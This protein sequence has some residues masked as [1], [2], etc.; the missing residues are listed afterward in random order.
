MDTF[1]VHMGGIDKIIRLLRND[2]G[3]NCEDSGSGFSQPV[4]TNILKNLWGGVGV[5]VFGKILHRDALDS[6]ILGNIRGNGYQWGISIAGVQP[7]KILK[8]RKR[9]GIGSVDHWGTLPMPS[10]IR[11]PRAFAIKGRVPLLRQSPDQH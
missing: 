6:E 5:P 11:V 8:S 3:R 4:H 9:E 7:D 2:R 1:E 10:A